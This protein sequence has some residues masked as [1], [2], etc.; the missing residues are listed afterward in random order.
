[1]DIAREKQNIVTFF[2]FE[3]ESNLQEISLKKRF[4]DVPT[5]IMEFDKD[6]ELMRLIDYDNFSEDVKKVKREASDDPDK[7]QLQMMFSTYNPTEAN[8]IIDYYTE[9]GYHILDVFMGRYTR[10]VI[11]LWRDRRYTGFDTC[12]KTVEAN[13]SVL[14][15]KFPEREK[16][17]D[18]YHSSGTDLEPFSRR[19]NVFDAVYSCPPYYDKEQYS[20]EGKDLSY[21]DEQEFDREIQK[22][23]GR[24]ERLIKPSDYDEEEFHPVI[25]KVGSQRKR[26]QGIVNDMQFKFKKWAKE[27]GFVL[28]DI[29]YSKNR[30]PLKYYDSNKAYKKRR[31]VKNFE[32]ILVFL[33]YG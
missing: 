13:R 28:H 4:G 15:E 21:M 10:P 17:W 16:D 18:L 32:T 24:L 1:M 9:P 29:I 27:S 12:S 8:F 7:S 14:R 11:S 6:P 22:M 33:N 23:F 30:T 19:E 20:G 3:D 31:V 26:D 5:T 25:F 2:D